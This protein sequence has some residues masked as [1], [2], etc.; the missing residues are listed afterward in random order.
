MEYVSFI[1]TEDEP[2]DLILSFAIWQPE[3][4]EVRSLILIRA[5][6]YEFI[7]DEAERGVE[8]SDDAWLNDEYEMLKE[9]KFDG[10]TVTVVTENHKFELDIRKVKAGEIKEAQN[11]LK[12]M[13]FDSR[14]KVTIV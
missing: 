11:I 3:L 9:I 2:P 4:D 1:S 12:R 13:N 14:F 8:V 10:D 7:F 5:P 6:Q